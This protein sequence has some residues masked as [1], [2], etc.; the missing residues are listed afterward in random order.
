MAK[1]DKDNLTPEDCEQ[2]ISLIENPRLIASYD[3]ASEQAQLHRLIRRGLVN[4]TV[5][6]QGGT[7]Y[8]LT[9]RG[10][11]A[12]NENGCN[13]GSGQMVEG[14]DAASNP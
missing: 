1:A 7:I 6:G 11:R 4:A 12:L 5:Y 14:H 10:E 3:Y 13:E 9:Q 2:L 8:Y